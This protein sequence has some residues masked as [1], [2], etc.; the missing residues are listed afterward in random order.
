[1]LAF[2]A[3]G[4][5]IFA[6]KLYSLQIANGFSIGCLAKD[7]AFRLAQ[8]Q[9]VKCSRLRILIALSQLGNVPFHKLIPACPQYNAAIAAGK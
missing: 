6:C 9:W 3:G 1:M 7:S 5:S 2:L 4:T 8:S